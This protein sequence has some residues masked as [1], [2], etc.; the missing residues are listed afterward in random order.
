MHHVPY[1]LL[2]IFA[3]ASIEQEYSKPSFATQ[4]YLGSKAACADFSSR[5]NTLE[6]RQ[7]FSR[8]APPYKIFLYLSMLFHFNGSRNALVTAMSFI[9]IFSFAR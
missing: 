8:S 3:T 9:V 1:L 2:I 4:G 7:V 5:Q 6:V